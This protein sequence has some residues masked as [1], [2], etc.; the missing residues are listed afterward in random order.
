MPDLEGEIM[1]IEQPLIPEVRFEWHPKCST[2]YVIPIKP[3]MPTA[4]PI[5]QGLKTASGAYTAVRLWCRGYLA[6]RQGFAELETKESLDDQKPLLTGS[7]E[8]EVLG[9][10]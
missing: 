5:I 2:V 3:F 6:H 8:K 4:E 1:H 10:V 9:V 7:H